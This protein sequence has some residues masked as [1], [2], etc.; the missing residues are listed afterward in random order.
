M[1]ISGI[2]ATN[3]SVS[4][5]K[6]EM[7]NTATDYS[8]APED[9]VLDY[10]TKDNQIKATITQYQTTNDGKVS[11]AQ[12][13]ATTAL[14]QVAT[15]VSQ[16]DYDQKTGDLSSK[17][18]QVKQTA[19]SQAADIVDIKATATSQASKINSIS[20]DVDGTKQSI[21]DIKTTQDSHSDKINQITSDVNGTKQ[22]ITDIQTKDGQQD[23]RMGSIETSVSGVKSDFS[24]YKTTNDGAVKTAQTTAQTAVDG[25]KN[26]VSQTDYNTKTGQLQTDLT[27]TTQ[28]ANQAKTDIVSIK[29]KDGD[30]DARMTQI[31]SD[32]SGVKTTV[33][34]LQTAQGKQSGDISTLQQ[35]ADGFDATV[36]KVNN[37]AVGGRNY[38]L[39]SKRVLSSQDPAAQHNESNVWWDT[40]WVD[41]SI[42]ISA[43][44]NKVF[45]ISVQ[46]DYD[47]VTAISTG[48]RVGIEI[49]AN[50]VNPN[51]SKKSR[52]F[53]VWKYVKNAESFHGRISTTFDMRGIV[54]ESV[55][56][57][58]HWGQGMYI[59][60]ITATN[61]S[62]SDPKL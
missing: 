12:T 4:D 23:T 43:F 42:P 25:L 7:G 48:A 1:Y 24:S 14:G 21:S 6:L 49:V 47:N 45:T 29:Q 9:V 8:P 51:G 59:S 32:A 52:Y 17:Y 44:S 61:V 58:N 11:K 60:G 2:T 31:E 40:G 56:T 3:V 28:T 16:T 50:E 55:Y 5:P 15:K 37:L 13:D 33:S 36:T 34:D 39:N 53:G 10:T 19:D 30:Q 20:S 38:I 41:T 35:R 22:S 46:L 54:L 57:P 26:K 27:T 62:V 18:T